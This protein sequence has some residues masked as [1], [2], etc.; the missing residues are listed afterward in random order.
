MLDNGENLLA[1]RIVEVFANNIPFVFK[2]KF[3]AG[4]EKSFPTT[5]GLVVGT[6]LWLLGVIGAIM[7]DMRQATI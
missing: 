1:T 4:Q 5:L 7:M 6:N 2:D 3:F